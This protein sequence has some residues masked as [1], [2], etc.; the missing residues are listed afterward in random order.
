M[1]YF[2]SDGKGREIYLNTKRNITFLKRRRLNVNGRV[3]IA[4]TQLKIPGLPILRAIYKPFDSLSKPLIVNCIGKEC[5][6]D[7]LALH[8]DF[9]DHPCFD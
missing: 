8:P 6:M 2:F 9:L 4:T 7:F 5:F 3:R 1:I